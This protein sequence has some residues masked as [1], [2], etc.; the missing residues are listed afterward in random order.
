MEYTLLIRNE[1]STCKMIITYM[2]NHDIQCRVVN[3]DEV[4]NVN[5]VI[6]VPALTING[7]VLA[8]GQDIYTYLRKSPT[9][10]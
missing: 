8:Y 4:E 7:R 6:V 10:D 1:C 2:E 3:L 5:S 9:L